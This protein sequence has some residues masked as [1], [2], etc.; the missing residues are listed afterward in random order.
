M[1]ILAW[2]LQ[3]VLAFYYMLYGTVLVIPPVH[4]RRMFADIPFSFRLIVAAFA[5]IFSLLLV[6]SGVS[7]SLTRLILPAP[8]VLMV[9]GGGEFVLRL[10]MTRESASPGSRCV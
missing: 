1:T 8:V 4:M 7:K 2:V 10:I 5:A 3:A 9:I 6:L